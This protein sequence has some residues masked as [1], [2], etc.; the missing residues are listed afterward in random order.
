[1]SDISGGGRENPGRPVLAVSVAI[2][3]EGRVLLAARGREPMQGVFTL[4]GGA[5]EAG[6]RLDEAARREVLEE[7]GLSI[8]AM[9]FVS[10]EELIRIDPE[11]R[12]RAHFVI[13]V[14]ATQWAGGE[15]AVTDEATAF[16]WADPADLGEIETTPNLG[17]VLTLA[18]ATL[19]I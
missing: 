9:R 2:F 14:F 19:A 7:T 6:E 10:H 15:P 3:R 13:C 16:V 8:G 11:N 5:V 12:V 1:M 17:A 4:P 18:K